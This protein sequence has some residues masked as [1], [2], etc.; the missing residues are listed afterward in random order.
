MSAPKCPFQNLIIAEEFVCHLGLA[1]TARNSPQIHCR[2]EPALTLC[3]QVY[4][5]F[6]AVGLP[7]LGM[8]D[9]LT[10]TP[11]S[12]YLKIQS[13]GLRGLKARLGTG[14]MG[15]APDIHELIQAA[16]CGGD[17]A[18]SLPYGELV[19]AMLAQQAKRRGTR[20]K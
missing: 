2:S 20:R 12:V 1:V 10:T 4:D 9:D 15:D 5:C 3:R 7:A 11:H 14:S 16:T 6:K 17:H 18:E 19:P 13:G 8:E